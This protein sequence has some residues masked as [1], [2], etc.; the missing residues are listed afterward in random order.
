MD[1][2]ISAKPLA[3]RFCMHSWYVQRHLR[4]F[5]IGLLIREKISLGTVILLVGVLALSWR[6]NDPNARPLTA[7]T[8]LTPGLGFVD[9]ES[10]SEAETS[11]LL[12]GDE[13]ADRP[14]SN[15][16]MLSPIFKTPTTTNSK[17]YGS[18]KSR[19]SGILETE[20]ILEELEDDALPELFSP[21]AS[22]HRRT[23]AR[24]TPSKVTAGHENEDPRSDESCFLLGRTGTGRSYRDRRRRRRSEPSVASDRRGHSSAES[25][26]EWWKMKW[27]KGKYGNL[28][29]DSREDES[30]GR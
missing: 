10:E 7:Q 23:S 9:S 5:M 17:F 20:E 18:T 14:R 27:W 22:H 13:E 24:S 3:F 12:D 15:G 25:L 16:R 21:A 29:E 30:E 6:L 4:F 26:Q 28:K 19:R 2:S 1:S 11:L 8:P